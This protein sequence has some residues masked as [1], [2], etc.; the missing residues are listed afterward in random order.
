MILCSWTPKHFYLWR[1]LIL[2]FFGAKIEGKPFVHQS[3]IIKM[4]WNLIMFDHSC[5]GE[6]VNIYNL[7]IIEIRKDAVIAQEAYLCGGTHKFDDLTMPL[8]T[9]KIIIGEN[10][11]IGAR[12]FI[13]PGIR[14]G[15]KSIVG[16]CSVVTK[17][18]KPNSIVAGNPARTIKNNSKYE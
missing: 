11:F 2:K 1:I 15:R 17:N 12:A 10:S 14:I 9:G 7:G 18:V 4:P 3:A 6:K 16:A 13:L 8:Q 5:I